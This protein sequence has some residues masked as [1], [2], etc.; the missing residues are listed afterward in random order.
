MSD[1]LRPHGLQHIGVPRTSLSPGV[2]SDSYSL[3]RWCH[4]NVIFCHP[5]L[6]LPSIFPSI[7]VFSSESAFHS[8]WPKYWRL[9]F[10]ISA[11]SEYS[12]L[13]SLVLNLVNSWPER[14]CTQPWEKGPWEMLC[15]SCSP[16]NSG[17]G[18]AAT[19]QGFSRLSL[20]QGRGWWHSAASLNGQRERASKTENELP[21]SFLQ[22]ELRPA[23][24]LKGKVRNEILKIAQ[25]YLSNLSQLKREM[26]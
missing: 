22:S 19:I 17:V 1:C 15:R 2:C 4:P 23:P 20:G 25:C 6:L 21:N 11:S 10:N 9:S 13:I 16:R 18:Q 24:L 14:I 12:G 3:S 26:R 8:R 7:R 5:L